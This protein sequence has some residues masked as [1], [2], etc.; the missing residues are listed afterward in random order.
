MTLK[1]L[2]IS[3][4]HNYFGRHGKGSMDHV[5]EEVEVMRCVA[6]HGIEGDRFYDFEPDYKGQ[7]TFFDWAVYQ[8]V[9][10]EIVKGELS[11]SAFR[12]NVLI[13]GVD[14][15]ELIGK[16]FTLG[17]LEFTGSGECKPCYWMDEACAPG[18][19]EFL[20]GRGGL[21]TRIVQGG[22][23]TPG[24]YELEVTGEVEPDPGK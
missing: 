22:K 3:P 7:L 8:E 19:F 17:G 16:R 24:D 5:I 21:R 12:R 2:Y 10:E 14:L 6:G 18:A 15:N 4:G 9:Q 13:E 20:K 1:Q 23:L 11:P